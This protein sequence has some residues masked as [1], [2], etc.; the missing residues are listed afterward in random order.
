[1]ENISW[2]DGGDSV[3]K[4]ILE[5]T[6]AN[7]GKSYLKSE[8]YKNISYWYEHLWNCPSLFGMT[9]FS[10]CGSVV[11]TKNRMSKAA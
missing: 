9:I 4:F 7:G 11:A 5:M 6:F 2:L 1:M 8:S 10:P 3:G